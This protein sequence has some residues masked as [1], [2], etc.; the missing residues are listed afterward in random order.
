M[1]KPFRSYRSFNRGYTGFNYHVTNGHEAEAVAEELAKPPNRFGL[2]IL[3]LLGFKGKPDA[4]RFGSFPVHPQH[5]D[6]DRPH[7]L[8]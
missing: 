7:H 2:F 6:H 8:E 5:H 1:A 4:E 3:R